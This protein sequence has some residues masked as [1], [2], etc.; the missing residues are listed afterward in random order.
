M[1][2]R[3]GIIGG[4]L[5]HS[6]SPVL[7]QAAFAHLGIDASYEVW[8]T[9][10]DGLPGMLEW[11]RQTPDVLGANVTV[12]IVIN[13]DMAAGMR[14]VLLQ[15]IPEIS[16]QIVQDVRDDLRRNPTGPFVTQARS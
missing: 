7:Q 13:A 14:S 1:T 10:A 5:A 2:Y 3:V 15:L 16:D 6:V 9:P 11:L 4:S 12:P 8:E